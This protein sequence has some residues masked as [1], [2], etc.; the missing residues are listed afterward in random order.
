MKR[1]HLSACKII[2]TTILLLAAF[3]VHSQEKSDLARKMTDKMKTAL[4]LTDEQYPKVLAANEQFAAQMAALKDG[5]GSRLSKLKKLKAMDSE[6]DKALKT[7][8]TE[9]QYATFVEQKKENRTKAGA[10]TRGTR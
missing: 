7:V 8:L 3:S 4:S 6:R 5:G 2:L 9:A 10:R 1:K